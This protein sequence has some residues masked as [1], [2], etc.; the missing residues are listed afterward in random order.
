MN[1]GG[2]M[3]DA[4]KKFGIA[5]VTNRD[6]A[7]LSSAAMRETNQAPMTERCWRSRLIEE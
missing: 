1:V 2:A 3:G 7:G 4:A 5:T 6:Y